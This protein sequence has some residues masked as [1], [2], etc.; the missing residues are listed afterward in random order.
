MVSA[1]QRYDQYNPRYDQD[2]QDYYR[3][4]TAQASHFV[5]TA[6]GSVKPPRPRLGSAYQRYDQYNP[7]YDQDVQDYYRIP[8]AQAS[9]WDYSA[10]SAKRRQ[11][12]RL[13]TERKARTRGNALGEADRNIAPPRPQFTSPFGTGAVAQ[14]AQNKVKLG[15]A[16]S[17]SEDSSSEEARPRRQSSGAKE[18]SR[19]DSS[20]S[21]DEPAPAPIYKATP[22]KY[23]NAYKKATGAPKVRFGRADRD[24][25]EAPVSPKRE[26]R[27]SSGSSNDSL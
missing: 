24:S 12:P 8:T 3:I 13:G 11:G 15:R 20:S 4:P 16:D 6:N 27:E 25:F 21:F 26:R 14:K 7:R 5:Y 10:S 1:Y 18:L 9:H 23:A 17:Y 22:N 2:V 19:S